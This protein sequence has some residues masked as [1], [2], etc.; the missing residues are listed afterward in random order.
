MSRKL[1]G[2]LSKTVLFQLVSIILILFQYAVVEA[3]VTGG[4]ARY[5]DVYGDRIVFTAS[6][7]LWLSTLEGG[8]ATRLTSHE[9]EERFA[10]F[11]PD[12]KSIAFSGNY[13]GNEDVFL[14]PVDGGEPK[15]LTFHPSQDE[16]V[17]WDPEGNIVFRSRRE[18]PRHAWE[19]YTVSPDG[20]WPQKIT[21]RFKDSLP[22][23]RKN[24]AI[25]AD[26]T[27]PRGAFI[28]F[29]PGGRRIALVNTFLGFHPWKRYQGGYAE[30]I[31]IGNPYTPQFEMVTEYPG[32]ESF[33]MWAENG[34]VYFVSDSTGRG[35]L[36]SMLPDGGEMRQETFLDTYDIR[37][38]NLGDDKIIFQ[39]GADLKVFSIP[40]GNLRTLSIHVPTDRYVAMKKFV[41]PGD[42]LTSWSLSEDGRRLIATARGELFTIPVERSGIIRQWTF[43]SN[44]REKYGVMLPAGGLLAISDFTGEEQVARFTKPGSTPDLLEEN[45]RD[46]W[47]YVPVP[48]PDGNKIAYADYTQTL[49]VV[50]I[51]SGKTRTVNSGEWEYTEYTWS[52]D[53]RYLAY[54]RMGEN[55]QYAVWI[56]DAE[57]G[58]NYPA[59]DPHFSTH[60]PA[61]DPSG[62]YLYCISSR[63]FNGYQDYDRGLFLYDHENTITLTR[64]RKEIPSP[65]LAFGDAP[66]GDKLPE[67]P[68]LDSKE[69]EKEKKKDESASDE[70]TIDFEGLIERTEAVPVKP[71]NFHHLQ[72]VDGKIY[73]QRREVSGIF[74]GQEL[75][76]Y[77]GS[78]LQAFDLVKREESEVASHVQSYQVSGNGKILVLRSGGQWYH[79]DAAS[80]SITLDGDHKINTDGWE[81]E[82]TPKEEWRQIFLEAWRHQRDFFF[83]PNLHGVDWKTVEEKYGSM[84]D[85]AVTRDDVRD[86][87][88]EVFSELH[89]G[90]AYIGPGDEP[91]PETAPVGFLG[92]DLEPDEESGYYRITRILAPEPG[93]KDGCSPLYTAD[94]KAGAGT[95]ILAI[96][97]RSAKAGR[98]LNELLQN[99]AGKEVA[100]VLN[101]KPTL[102]GSREVVIRTMKNDSRLRYYDWVKQKRDYVARKSGGKIGYVQ[103]PDMGG[104]GLS[105]WGRDYYPQRRLPGMIIDDRYNGGG[106]VSEYFLKEL[107]AEVWAFQSARRGV[108]E[109]KPHGGYF[110]HLAVLCNGE[111]MSDGE[112]F[113]EATKILGLG[114]LIGERTWGGWVWI[115]MDKPLV[116]NAYISE[117][118]FG[119]WG[120]DGK[121]M[122]EGPGVSPDREVI[123]DP[124]S[125]ILGHDPQLDAAIEYLLQKIEEEPREMPERPAGVIK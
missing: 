4:F 36:W 102:K 112:S 97:G 38:P 58:D 76:G 49:F 81:I 62:K 29:E 57:T 94:P 53:S 20:G 100:V 21:F 30:K 96:N 68:W 1:D 8:T 63:N 95:Y 99:Q 16:V 111:T 85:L 48:S 109:T 40:G 37:W 110:G 25:A 108:R 80:A 114:P 86:L 44:A 6:G 82:V 118:E 113:A 122:I 18:A 17:G 45:Q 12:G 125:E 121:W 35:N 56:Y 91:H 2:I 52:P 87:I 10:F 93:T 39:H 88:R 24:L 78:Y 79:G 101:E 117:P 51:K 104:P 43:S 60:S 13:Y 119:G 90:H 105:Q 72:A 11:S 67:A 7:D 27:L 14:I 47:K 77:E 32:N 41:N 83:D 65:F 15:Q 28:S 64:L 70:I 106:N 9:G 92:V 123:N 124:A 107:N 71:G 59:S 3:S 75:R 46:G 19:L 120:F 66:A 5:P 34:R 74:S 42:Y 89:S 31:W 69:T 98:N 115:R 61:W 73:Y 103:L 33:P 23:D 50:D 22:S 55:L 26:L 116:D 54:S 84:L